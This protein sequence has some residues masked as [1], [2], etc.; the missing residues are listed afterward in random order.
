MLRHIWREQKNTQL[1]FTGPDVGVQCHLGCFGISYLTSNCYRRMA[2]R[3]HR[4]HVIP[5]SLLSMAP[6]AQDVWSGSR[7]LRGLPYGW[8]TLTWRAHAEELMGTFSLVW[9]LV[10]C[11]CNTGTHEAGTSTPPSEGVWSR[12][13]HI[14][15]EAVFVAMA[16]GYIQ[17]RGGGAAKLEFGDW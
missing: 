17:L 2:W 14:S 9:M 15:S 13:T 1:G 5:T 8:A 3:S 10:E 7:H 6:V 16:G 4:S 11:R 12:G